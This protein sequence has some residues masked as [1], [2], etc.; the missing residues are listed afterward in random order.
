VTPDRANAREPF[1]AP[2]WMR[3][4]AQ[5]TDWDSQ[6]ATSEGYKASAWVYRSVSLRANAIAS[7]PWYVETRR[8]GDW[9]RVEPNHPLQVLL[10]SPNPEMEQADLMRLLVTH[11]DLA[12][13]GYWAKVRQGQGIVLELWPML[14]HEMEII[15]GNQELVEAYRF[16][17]KELLAAQNVAHFAYC[18][19]AS[20][21]Y[22]QAPL[23]AAGK[24]VD[25][26]NAAASWQKISLQNR[27]IPDGVFTYPE[28]LTPEQFAE[29][30]KQ[31]KEQYAT[32]GTAREPWLVGGAQW[33]Q[34][35]LS[36]VEMD[37]LNTRNV[38]REEI[39]IVYGTAEMLASLASANRASAQE[40]RKSF[41]LDTII[42]LLRELKSALNRSVARE[43]GPA[44]QIRIVYDTSSVEA[45]QT[46]EK[47][48]LEVVKGYWSM[49]VPF[50]QLN[51]KYELGFEDIEGGDVGY[52][53]SGLVPTDFD[54]DAAL[55]PPDQ[56]EG[57]EEP[58]ELTDEGLKALALLTYGSSDRK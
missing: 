3:G 18:N 36:P 29:G 58:P 25:V 11:L 24:A 21:L 54:F 4:S 31:I 57:E 47:E 51:Q 33:Q 22:G 7:V 45:L 1:L 28:T 27:G 14:P 9:E 5:W 35:S 15:P 12:G 43:F 26:D 13:N 48:I 41:W 49:G 44:D 32:Q 16:R 56:Q 34:M 52:L 42:P 30:R 6:K 53:P 46:N 38:T 20:L 19:P 23:M 55:Q 50:N 17:S 8:G 39:G 37:Y 10:D 40:V 2:E